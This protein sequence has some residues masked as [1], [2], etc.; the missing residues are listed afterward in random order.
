MSK[1]AAKFDMCTICR[2]IIYNKDGA[3]TSKTTAKFDMH[4]HFRGNIQTINGRTCRK[5][6]PF[7][8]CVRNTLKYSQIQSVGSS[9][10]PRYCSGRRTQVDRKLE[11]QKSKSKINRRVLRFPHVVVG[12]AEDD[13]PVVL[14]LCPAMQTESYWVMGLWRTEVK[15]HE[16]SSESDEV[17]RHQ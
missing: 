1:T 10:V 7:L 15:R 6:R 12:T 11:Y 13:T 4:G 3:C 8:T 2:C 14:H 9:G 5:R 16:P 17:Q